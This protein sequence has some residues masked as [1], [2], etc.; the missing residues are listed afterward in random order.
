MAVLSPQFWC[1]I[2]VLKMDINYDNFI[3]D[4]ITDWWKVDLE[5]KALKIWESV[6]S[7]GIFAI[8]GSMFLHQILLEI[9]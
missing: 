9:T 8:Q 6:Q 7:I 3:E 2:F 1:K 5:K 4:V